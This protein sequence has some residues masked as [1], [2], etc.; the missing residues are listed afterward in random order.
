PLPRGKPSDFAPHK[1]GGSVDEDAFGHTCSLRESISSSPGEAG[2]RIPMSATAGGRPSGPAGATAGQELPWPRLPS[3]MLGYRHRASPHE[4]L[5]SEPGTLAP[6]SRARGVAGSV[7]PALS[8]ADRAAGEGADGRSATHHPR[9]TAAHMGGPARS[10]RP[11]QG[12]PPK[13]ESGAPSRHVRQSP[14]SRH[15]ALNRGP[16]GG[17]PLEPAVRERAQ[18]SLGSAVGAA[19]IHTDAA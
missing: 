13:V 1:T 12:S 2:A 19:R 3:G 7:L 16:A 14:A 6:R 11:P 18:A 5:V 8:C 4:A 15:L 9:T 10:A 17:R